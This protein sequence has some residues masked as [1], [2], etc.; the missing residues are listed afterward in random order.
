M[1]DV[2]KKMLSANRQLIKNDIEQYVTIESN[3]IINNVYRFIDDLVNQHINDFNVKLRASNV[4]D[5]LQYPKVEQHQV[6]VSVNDTQVNAELKR[7]EKSVKTHKQLR[8]QLLEV[9]K[10][11]VD[12]IQLDALK[13]N[14]IQNATYYFNDIDHK[15]LED[16]TRVL[17][18]LN[19]PIEAPDEVMYKESI[20]LLNE[21]HSIVGE[22]N[23]NH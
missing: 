20:D 12:S 1:N 18:M 21:I 10:T 11:I 7:F 14:V 6:K 3:T 9:S 22:E 5:T 4:V 17:Q 15:L 2:S 8:E 16:K 19:T 13:D 23:D